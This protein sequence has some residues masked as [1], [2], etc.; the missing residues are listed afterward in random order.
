ME[1]TI[2]IE[3]DDPITVGKQDYTSI[4]LKEPTV[5]QLRVAFKE[6]NELNMSAR[7]VSLIANVPIAVID[8]IPQSKFKEATDFLSQFSESEEESQKTSEIL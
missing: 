2:V 3:F 1:D 8:A 5:G 4:T 6:T 7:L